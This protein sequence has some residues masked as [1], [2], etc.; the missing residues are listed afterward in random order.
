MRKCHK[1]IFHM[2]NQTNPEKTS[3]TKENHMHYMCIVNSFPEKH[4]TANYIH[5]R[6]CVHSQLP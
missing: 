1:N 4:K 5:K 2:W 6:K 3:E